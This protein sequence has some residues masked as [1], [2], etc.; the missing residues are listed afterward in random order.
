MLNWK[1]IVR[2]ALALCILSV[3]GLHAQNEARLGSFP[4]AL[5]YSVN[6]YK[7]SAQIWH[8][9]QGDD[10]SLYFA[11]NKG[12]LL[13]NGTRWTRVLTEKQTPVT[14][15]LKTSSGR[16]VVG[17]RNEIGYL[18]YSEK[19]QL[20][21]FPLGKDYLQNHPIG[22]I[23]NIFEQPDKKL[24]VVGTSGVLRMNFDGTQFEQILELKD[25]KVSTSVRFGK[26][27]LFLVK[28]QQKEGNTEDNELLFL[29]DGQRV[30]YP[31]ALPEIRP[32]NLRGVIQEGEFYHLFDERG[33]VQTARFTASHRFEWLPARRT[34]ENLHQ[35]K[36]NA[37]H[38][39]NNLIYVGT[40]N[41]GLL[42]YDKNGQLVRKISAN[43]GLEN[44]SVFEFFFD[45]NTNLWLL[46]D[47]GISMIELSSPVT[48]FKKEQGIIA[49]TEAI[50]RFSDR[51]LLA[52]RTDLFIDRKTEGY[53]DFVNSGII[54]EPTFDIRV[55]QTDFGDKCLV[56][57]Y[58]GIYE[59]TTAL[60]K[61]IVQFDTYA[62]TLA[63][64]ER[65][66][67]VI[68]CGFDTPGGI[69][70][71]TFDGKKWAFETLLEDAG[72]EVRS[73]AELN[74]KLY[75][76]VKEKGIG[77]YDLQTKKV[78]YIHENPKLKENSVYFVTRFQDDLFVGS[79]NG[80]YR[81]KGN[82]LE[83]FK[84][85][86]KSLNQSK[87]YIHRMHN[88]SNNRL[89]M[90][91]FHNEDLETEYR[92]IGYLEKHNG[93]W[94]WTRPP[95]P[96]VEQ[97]V[98][99]AIR[100]EDSDYIWFGGEKGVY[101]YHPEAAK[102]INV[103]FK[104][105]INKVSGT[106]DTLYSTLDQNLILPFERNSIRF[107]FSTPIFYGA[108][109]VRYRTRL[110]GF[111]NQW[112]EWSATNTISFS[113][114]PEGSYRFEVQSMDM[115]GKESEID[116]FSFSILPPWY[117]TW[118]AFSLFAL[119]ALIGI[120]G[121][122]RLSIRRVKQQNEKLEQTVQERTQ[123]I[124][125]QKTK[126]ENINRD[127]L[128]SIKYAKRIQNTILPDAEQLTA[129]H[130][131][132]VVFYRPKDIVS[133][134]FYWT[135]QV[136]DY[137]LFAAIDCTGHGVPGAFVSIVGYNGLIRA[138]NEFGLYKPNEIL[139]KLR[140]IVTESFNTQNQQEVKDGM[141]MSLCAINYRTGELLFSGA[142]NPCVIIRNGEIIELK[143][144]KQPIGQFENPKPFALQT[145][146]LEKGDCVY[147][148]TDGYIDQFGGSQTEEGGK[149]FK[150]KPFKHLLASIYNRSM[151]DQQQ[152][153]EE[154]FENWKDTLEQVDDVCVIGIKY[155]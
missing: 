134:D 71:L 53:V 117:R 27:Y 116:A 124:A 12:V 67:N 25:N 58:N 92:E 45:R 119:L 29:P 99:H 44:I 11:N 55:F 31:A 48:V 68:Y 32:K 94:Q 118:W 19:G 17:A 6:D 74:G 138:V 128:D 115:Y 35:Y 113:R 73:I 1:H 111:D 152:V 70:K 69:G 143:G 39:K 65:N 28:I 64:S 97:D 78:N 75:F 10:G 131:N 40:D 3:H 80:L 23:W 149:K 120:Y 126:I 13:F 7:A 2:C 127:I 153:L 52:T 129:H 98:I 100:H 60:T 101:L 36:V 83:P 76:S 38:A 18:Q 66:R 20:T 107:E 140:E 49:A 109:K 104:T 16:I 85:T 102:Y 4:E 141:D 106:K 114:L 26:G 79:N 37:V 57:G 81:I 142:N 88:E 122:I 144:D 84:E 42:I 95:L 77:I 43:E 72:G 90:V 34:F 110:V 5:T 133:G 155:D 121:L 105:Y 8:G 136:G 24:L 146:S 103:P 91:L 63:Q 50:A 82:D 150:S 15:L 14:R 56:I 145:F 9:L 132:H 135:E 125:N 123:E 61:Q 93:N 130:P 21:Y 54:Q 51:T 46:L 62:W 151:R 108:S 137:A 154:T 112:S 89:W 86:E 87:L 22:A 139:D 47:N 30:C 148:Y 41:D 147:L 96:L 59:L 33:N